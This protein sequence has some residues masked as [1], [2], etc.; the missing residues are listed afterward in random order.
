MNSFFR[1]F[2][3]ITQQKFLQKPSNITLRLVL[4]HDFKIVM[5]MI[6]NNSGKPMINHIYFLKLI[7]DLRSLLDFL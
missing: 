3:K 4:E 1:N 5:D 7:L 6:N 2:K